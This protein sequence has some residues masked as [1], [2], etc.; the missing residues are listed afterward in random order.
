MNKKES[1]AAQVSSI[2]LFSTFQL[3]R[4]EGS[5]EDLDMS[6]QKFYSMSPKLPK[7]PFGQR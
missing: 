2:D 4:S 6:G 3:E 5:K 1:M 7:I